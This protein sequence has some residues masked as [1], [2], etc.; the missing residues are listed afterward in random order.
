MTFTEQAYTEKDYGIPDRTLGIGAIANNP[1]N[2][3]IALPTNFI[4]TCS[5]LPSLAYFV[6]EVTLPD[7]G[8]EALSA[9][10][11][12]G[13]TVKLPKS[14]AVYGSI[15]LKF[16][17]NEDFSNYHSLI[18]W[19]LENTPYTEF[20]TSQKPNFGSIDTASLILLT[21]KKIPYRKF[22]MTGLLP[23]EL[24]GVEFTTEATDAIYLTA[25]VK[26]SVSDFKMK[27]L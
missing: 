26:F 25:T 12:I 20:L 14:T 4:F 16:L 18:N 8:G 22:E 19:M 6:Q 9:E 17:I 21:N 23:T 10:Y 2:T 1:K 3:N 24:S 15:T 13:P 7:A 27:S 5:K 11:M